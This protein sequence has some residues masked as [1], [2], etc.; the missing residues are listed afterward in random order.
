MLFE[1]MIKFSRKLIILM[2][3]C[4]DCAVTYKIAGDGR[5]ASS[6]VKGCGQQQQR[7]T[8]QTQ[9]GLA[10]VTEALQNRVSHESNQHYY[11]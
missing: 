11:Y 10:A 5:S 6:K 3:P 2:C 4:A 7:L 1:K 9:W 8:R